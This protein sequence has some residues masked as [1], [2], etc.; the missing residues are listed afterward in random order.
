M[1]ILNYTTKIDPAKTAGEIQSLLGAKGAQSVSTQYIKGE[2][3]A[4]FFAIEVNGMMVNFRLPC[5][6]EGVLQSFK[7]D[8]K[9]PRSAE[10][11]EQA[12]RTAWRIIKDWVEA[13]LAII[14]SGQAQM[15]EVF[16]PYAMVDNGQTIY[17]RLTENPQL[18]LEA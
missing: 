15:A 3:V 6:W 5:N 1:P 2:A 8:R 10:T 11:E 18:L 17:Q 14:E 13:Q 12:K 9:V 4:V 16:M 7:R